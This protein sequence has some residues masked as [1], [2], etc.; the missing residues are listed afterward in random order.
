MKLEPEN[1]VMVTRAPLTLID[2][3]K[4]VVKLEN[5]TL[6]CYI[7]EG[8][9]R[10]GIAFLG[11]CSYAVDAIAET[12][13]GAVGQSYTGQLQGVQIFLG[14]STVEEI[15]KPPLDLDLQKYGFDSSHG[16][17]QSV[18]TRIDKVHDKRESKFQED[19]S[20]EK[21]ILLGNNG[22]ED[23][24]LV[25]QE[26]GLIFIQGKTV[27]VLNDDK[28]VSVEGK[29]IAISSGKG[30]EIMIDKDGIHGLDL[31]DVDEIVR[32]AMKSAMKGVSAGLKGVGKSIRHIEKRKHR[33]SSS[34]DDVDDLDWDDE[35]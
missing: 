7:T 20:K 1:Q 34:R 14:N 10:V 25:P 17:V 33:F 29:R 2:E 18:I 22:N 4:A 15:S 31:P 30:E 6:W 8:E 32:T 26:D 13:R 3:E 27:Y 35:E 16:F 28:L 5:G 24:I 23:I 12:S 9:N 11:N 19:D 21:N